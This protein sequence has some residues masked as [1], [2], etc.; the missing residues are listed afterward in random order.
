ML[1]EQ[2]SKNLK[3]GESLVRVV[4]RDFLAS[5]GTFILAGACILL[6]FFFLSWL[7]QHRPWGTWVFVIVLVIGIL[8]GIRA[9]V[10]WQLNTLLITNERVIHILQRGFFTR[11][12]SEA[13]HETV[14]DVRFRVHGV[15]QTI[16]GLGAI[17][18][19]TA[20]E[21]ENLRLEGVRRPADIQALITTVLRESRQQTG[22]PLS[23]QELVAA[24]GKMK[25]ELGSEAFKAA[26][27]KVQ[28]QP[29]PAEPGS[30]RR[31]T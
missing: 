8:I 26:I 25:S 30:T 13:R 12:V 9:T 16:F 28:D 11:T 22:T 17:E 23:A 31:R 15:V 18:V 5:G 4:R 19:Q 14:T 3:D 7:I 10:E 20:G 27:S 2:L 24:L 6:D 29:N 21:G 1:H